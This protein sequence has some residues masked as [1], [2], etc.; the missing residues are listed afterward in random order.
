[1]SPTRGQRSIRPMTQLTWR[2]WPLGHLTFT[3]RWTEEHLRRNLRQN[4]PPGHIKAGGG[5]WEPRQKSNWRHCYWDTVNK[6]TKNSETKATKGDQQSPH[7]TTTDQR[8]PRL[9]KAAQNAWTSTVELSEHPWTVAK[10]MDG[11]WVEH[12]MMLSSVNSWDV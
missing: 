12:H 5:Q 7:E 4:V 8:P 6:R 2:V 10:W 3:R 11:G 9:Q 1:M